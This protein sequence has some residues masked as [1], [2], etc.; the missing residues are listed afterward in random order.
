MIE[1]DATLNELVVNVAWFALST[2]VPRVVP[3]SLNVTVPLAVPV[4]VS[5]IVAVSVTL[6]PKT[7]VLALEV[8]VFVLLD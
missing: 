5:V 7:L 3:P 8:T 4:P 2:P 6:C 1:C